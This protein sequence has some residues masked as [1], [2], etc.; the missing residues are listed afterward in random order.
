MK[1]T[2]VLKTALENVEERIENVCRKAGRPRTDIQL[3][4]VTKTKP[5]ELIRQAWDLGLRCFAENYIQEAAQKRNALRDLDIDWHFIGH[6]Q[7]NKAKDVVGCF[8]LL[9]SLGTLSAARELSKHA[10]QRSL[11]QNVL[12]EINVAGEASKSGISLAQAD[13][14]Y[15]AVKALDGVL[16][17]GVMTMPP[18][19][20]NE[21]ETRRYFTS[22][23][24]W[25]V[26][27]NFQ[28][29]SMGTSD[30]FEWAIQEGATHIRLGTVLF[31][32]RSPKTP[33]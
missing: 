3:V 9:H 28:I 1:D 26:R 20:G 7:S 16:V 33:N 8:S 6:L 12:L 13:D 23:Y 14:F 5:Q 4:A 15:S 29:F 19:L 2:Q 27:Q 11:K 30:D 18:P 17:C 22:V 21:M 10:L 25:G 32:A 24:E 31:G